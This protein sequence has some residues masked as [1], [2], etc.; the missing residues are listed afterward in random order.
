MTVGYA[1]RTFRYV[2]YTYI[3]F[4]RLNLV[5]DVLIDYTLPV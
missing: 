2:M 1:L 3:N 5:D 4:P